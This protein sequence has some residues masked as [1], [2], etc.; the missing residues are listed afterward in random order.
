MRNGDNCRYYTRLPGDPLLLVS[1][2]WG[3]VHHTHLHTSLHR[4]HHKVKKEDPL[5]VINEFT[6]TVYLPAI[7]Q[8][9]ILY[10]DVFA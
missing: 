9:Y 2:E 3:D 1:E 7:G 6:Y 10:I 4:Y 8:L 5:T